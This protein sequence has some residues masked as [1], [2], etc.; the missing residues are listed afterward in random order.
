MKS[1]KIV[2]IPGPTPVVRSIQDQMG[3]ETVSFKDEDFVNDFK[4]VVLD[5]KKMWDTDGEAFIVAGSGTLAMEMAIANITKPGDEVLIISHGY[6]G[7]RFIELCERKKLN[8]D[9][10]KSEWGKI[11]QLEKI[12]KIN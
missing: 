1:K 2:M 12:E 3:K 11:V 7:D 8:I 10:L 4:E 9:L 6:F 5:L